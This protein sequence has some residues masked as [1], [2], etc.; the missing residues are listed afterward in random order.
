LVLLLTCHKGYYYS[1]GM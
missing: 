1:Q